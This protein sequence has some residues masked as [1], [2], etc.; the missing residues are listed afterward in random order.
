LSGNQTTCRTIQSCL[1]KQKRKQ[2]VNWRKLPTNR[3]FLPISYLRF[4][5]NY[6]PWLSCWSLPCLLPWLT[7][8][9]L[10]NTFLGLPGTRR[11][12]IE[13]VW[14]M[15]DTNL[16]K[17]SSN[18]NIHFMSKQRRR[19]VW[20]LTMY[21]KVASDNKVISSI[22]FL[23]PTNS[24]S[25]RAHAWTKHSFGQCTLYSFHSSFSTVFSLGIAHICISNP[26]WCLRGVRPD[27]STS[28]SIQDTS[29][30]LFSHLLRS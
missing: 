18:F 16:N 27:T 26:W 28:Y 10:T 24:S 3:G 1:N 19:L 11:E 25:L 21:K 5:I 2:L 12:N 4:I 30:G 6:V 15:F 14:I 13:Y 23:S 7:A 17:F 20:L 9:P 8:L 29:W 22:L